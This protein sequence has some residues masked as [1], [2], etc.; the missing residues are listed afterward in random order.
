MKQK[1]KLLFVE[2]RCYF[3]GQIGSPLYGIR[4]KLSGV[5]HEKKHT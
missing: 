5:E 4:E 1:K 2:F 3:L